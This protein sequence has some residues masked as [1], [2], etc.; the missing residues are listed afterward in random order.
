M[1]EKTIVRLTAH[2][3][4]DYEACKLYFHR[5][6]N[7]QRGEPSK[8]AKLAKGTAIHLILEHYYKGMKEGLEFNDRVTKAVELFESQCTNINGLIMEDVDPVISTFH[9]YTSWYQDRDNFK[10]V[11][12]EERLSK[13]LY[14]DDDYI[15]LWEGS[16]DLNVE[17]S[18]GLIIPYD[19]KSEGSK[20][21]PSGLGNQ[22]IGYAFLTNSNRVIR[23]AIGFQ[24]NKKPGEKFYR[25]MFSYSNDM[26]EWWKQNTINK[27][28]ELIVNYKNNYWPPSFGACDS[29][30]FNTGCPFR[31]VCLEPA[32][33]WP[34]MLEENFIHVDLYDR[35]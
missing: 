2:Y 22:F 23:N 17:S 34:Q 16:Q 29:L 8:P 27:A 18:E 1:S 15:I 3:L 21:N 33:L 11:S 32:G 13:V 6:V 5:T 20:R 4:D 25:T 30:H 19:H 9:E 12:V 7:L 31:Q 28:M 26:I 35:R 10:V 24:K 14:E